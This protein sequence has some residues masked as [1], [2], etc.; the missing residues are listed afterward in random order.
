M[1]AISSND[2]DMIVSEQA[3]AE[4]ELKAATSA[5]ADA[6][7]AI[8]TAQQATTN[9]AHN[10]P[11]STH[12]D[13]APSIPIADSESE[14]GE[15][16][17]DDAGAD[18]GAYEIDGDN[19]DTV[20]E[21][22]A[23]RTGMPNGQGK[24]PDPAI[25]H[26]IHAPDDEI[27]CG[28]CVT[29]FGH[30]SHLGTTSPAPPSA[31][32]QS[33]NDEHCDGMS[34]VPAELCKRL[35]DPEQRA[36]LESAV[37][38][39]VCPH[40]I[41]VFASMCKRTPCEECQLATPGSSKAEALRNCIEKKKCDAN[42]AEFRACSVTRPH[43]QALSAF[44]KGNL[45]VNLHYRWHANHHS[46]MQGEEVKQSEGGGD[47]AFKKNKSQVKANIKVT[48]LVIRQVILPSKGC[49]SITDENTRSACKHLPVADRIWRMDINEAF[50]RSNS[51]NYDITGQMGA[52][53]FYFARGH[54]GSVSQVWFA[55]SDTLQ[56][57]TL[58]RNIV[59]LFHYHAPPKPKQ[60]G[61][62]QEYSVAD[63]SE[64]GPLTRSYQGRVLENGGM[65]L[66]SSSSHS[67][68]DSSNV[69]EAQST[70]HSVDQHGHVT[71]AN[72]NTRSKSSQMSRDGKKAC[73]KDVS[74][75]KC[76]DNARNGL[77]GNRMNSKEKARLEF[78]CA[79]LE[80]DGALPH[81][82]KECPLRTLNQAQPGSD[83][84]S[85]KDAHTEELLQGGFHRDDRAGG[86]AKSMEPMHERQQMHI[87]FE[88]TAN[89]GKLRG[90]K[91]RH[92]HTIL[93]QLH[94]DP[95][96]QDFKG[97]GSA[98]DQMLKQ[99]LRED[100]D[101]SVHREAEDVLQIGKITDGVRSRLVNNMA[102]A[103][104]VMGASQRSIL[105]MLQ[106]FSASP[107]DE[108]EMDNVLVMQ[109]GQPHPHP[110]L[111]SHVE[112]LEEQHRN[113]PRGDA[114]LAVLSS[115]A[116]VQEKG[117]ATREKLLQRL[118][119]TAKAGNTDVAKR[120]IALASLGNV[121]DQDDKPLLL[122][123]LLDEHHHVREQAARSLRSIRGKDV[124]AA[125]LQSLAHDPVD[126]VKL[127]ALDVLLEH[128]T[129][130]DDSWQHAVS[131]LG[132]TSSDRFKTSMTQRFQE[133][134]VAV[135]VSAVQV[136]M[137]DSVHR[138]ACTT[139]RKCKNTC[140]ANMDCLKKC[141]CAGQK[142]R[143][144]LPGAE[145]FFEPKFERKAAGCG[146]KDIGGGVY[147]EALAEACRPD[148]PNNGWAAAATGEAGF[149]ADVLK[150]HWKI[151]AIK[152][153]AIKD[154]VSGW[155]F[156]GPSFIIF[157]KEVKIQEFE[158]KS[159]RN[160]DGVQGGFNIDS[161]DV[162]TPFIVI[163]F[164]FSKSNDDM[165]LVQRAGKQKSLLSKLDYEKSMTPKI[166]VAALFLLE[167]TFSM[168]FAMGIFA[169]PCS[170]KSGAAVVGI[171]PSY[172]G[173]VE[174]RASLDAVVVA[175]GVGIL[176]NIF[177]LH[178]PPYFTFW[179]SRPR[180]HKALCP[181]VKN[182]FEIQL[183]WYLLSGKF[184]VFF[185]VLFVTT[186]PFEYYFP[187]GPR[188]TGSWF[189]QGSQP[190]ISAH[191]CLL[192][193]AGIAACGL[194]SLEQREY[195]RL[196]FG[197]H[198]KSVPY[199]W[200]GADQKTCYPTKCGKRTRVCNGHGTCSRYGATEEE[201]VTEL[202][203]T[204]LGG[205]Q[206]IGCY[207]DNWQRDFKH[208]PKR[209]GYNGKRCKAA[210]PQY[211]YAALQNG[212]WCS[213]DNS[214]STPR[215]KYRK[216]PNSQCNKGFT[217]GG[218][219]WRNAV[220]KTRRSAGSGSRSSSYSWTHMVNS[221]YVGCQC[222]SGFQDSYC[223]T[224]PRYGR[225]ELK[226]E[227]TT[228]IK[229]MDG[230]PGGQSDVRVVAKVAGYT[231]ASQEKTQPDGRRRQNTWFN[232]HFTT[233]NLDD[234]NNLR[235]NVQVKDEDTI[236][237][238]SAGTKSFTMNPHKSQSWKNAQINGFKGIRSDGRRRR[239][240]CSDG[241]RRGGCRAPTDGYVNYKYRYRSPTGGR[242]K[243]N[244]PSGP[245]K[246]PI[247][248]LF[249]GSNDQYKS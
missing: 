120:V 60:V 229:D 102:K 139:C 156:I 113:T 135:D 98:A 178:L 88:R 33:R 110:L 227:K 179:T 4:M 61:L 234:T 101:G 159:G 46:K 92:F 153:S 41:C 28:K 82:M 56:F 36:K 242:H 32:L 100:M 111:H 147:A 240:T 154:S 44:D 130:H 203:D 138:T 114:L 58:K 95:E 185:K 245:Q 243:H 103:S 9:V 14:D 71:V 72:A 107:L 192:Q 197:A 163:P 216:K 119:H 187:G 211:K 158:S 219:P 132:S 176:L 160:A 20:Q 169:E 151:L 31:L 224:P 146:N 91:H 228:D 69:R 30:I 131:Q 77:S 81:G 73:I 127:S 232:R 55:A 21:L 220:Y 15:D 5:A 99:L 54:D 190:I 53:P 201:E 213:C 215:W 177:E 2:V 78:K 94:A 64:T 149:Y 150:Q 239:G 175:V 199:S 195:P 212:G 222:R 106:A 42:A 19:K 209:Y 155:G 170:K 121:G 202:V 189:F 210:C 123:S 231:F 17:D 172:S 191:F 43:F 48:D 161:C 167:F 214:Y 23:T 128:R 142:D 96:V 80:G 141:S 157:N 237:Y 89:P 70:R 230:W 126:L 63:I 3:V 241:R 97:R 86:V 35:E 217:G 143:K 37:N 193:G 93:A 16:D 118:R 145:Q 67:T 18:G 133:R 244:N 148:G 247:F 57:V 198:K 196:F 124:N 84:E 116:S 66:A 112:A 207:Q 152:A 188:N 233:G 24:S 134:G 164:P 13:A 34:D 109:V 236:G 183:S 25:K 45:G 8:Q 51:K 115:F 104:H 10:Q 105:R 173:G 29:F 52:N 83:H 180:G 117:E 140:G 85:K 87:Q 59:K 144:P 129:V 7:S 182:S 238:D 27:R 108:H 221:K 22:H 204:Q 75:G 218:G 235:V 50:V 174:A 49:D 205:V 162:V 225:V 171:D 6:D 90:D 26:Q 11:A 12:R 246:N 200:D 125:L 208:G 165:Q 186:Y 74:T 65:E 38:N 136:G 166:R 168:S 39:K 76:P 184:F 194:R 206:Y 122:A 223:E 249:V 1:M 40:E 226:L 62:L 68:D 181:N 47:R 137:M 79:T 248:D